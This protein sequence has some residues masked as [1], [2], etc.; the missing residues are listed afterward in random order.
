MCYNYVCNIPEV[1]VMIQKLITAAI[2]DFILPGCSTINEPENKNTFAFP[3]VEKD[4]WTA[5]F[6]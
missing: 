6:P 5:V 2:A 4:I 3:E 1:L